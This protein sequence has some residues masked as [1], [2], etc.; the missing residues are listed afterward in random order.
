VEDLCQAIHLCLTL[1]REIV[2]DTFNIGAREFGTMG[3]D[4]QAVLDRAGFGKRIRPTPA[5]PVIWTL[6]ILEAL[7]LSPLYK[8]VYET[9]SK[10]SFVSIEKAERVLGFDPKFSNQQALLRN[11]QWYLDNYGKFVETSGVSH[12]APWKQGILKLFKVFF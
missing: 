4:Y 10:D 2:N 7:K 11:Y 1:D 3:E 12:R 5:G 6:R 8:W 9:A